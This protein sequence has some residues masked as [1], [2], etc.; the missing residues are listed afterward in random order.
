MVKKTCFLLWALFCSLAF[1]SMAS[2]AQV[3][4]Y[5]TG[6][7]SYSQWTNVGCSSGSLEWQCVDETPASTSDYLST[8]KG[9]T[10]E[11]F[12]FSS[13]NLSNVEI[14][15]ITLMYYAMQEAPSKKCFEPLLRISGTDY[16]A[17]TQC[18]SSSYAYYVQ[19]YT[20]N[21]AT[22]LAWTLSELNNLEA[23][24]ESAS[25]SGGGRVAQVFVI[26]D[27]ENID[28][29]PTAYASASP[30][31]G[32]S[33]LLVYF[34]GTGVGGDGTLSYFWD[35]GDGSNSSVQNPSHTYS[36]GNYTATLYVSDIDNDVASDSVNIYVEAANQVPT[37]Y[38]SASPTSGTTPLLVYF[39]GTGVGGDGTLSYFWDF[40]DGS[41]SSVQNPSHTYS[42]GNYTA[43]LY[44]SDIDNDVASDSVNIYVE[45]A[46]QV[47]VIA[48]YAMQNT[49]NTSTAVT[50]V[51]YFIETGDEPYNYI[52]WDFGDGTIVN[53]SMVYNHTYNA[54]GTYYANLTVVDAN[55]DYAFSNNLEILV[56]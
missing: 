7:G 54:S 40:G 17:A 21:P 26:V 56:Y 11:S 22:G 2:A 29:I 51:G 34:N 44:V 41:N 1:T 9:N 45:A 32:T 39:N 19:S 42:E 38:A 49:T 48:A 23:G 43:T 37:A 14:S 28:L 36:E 10:L 24:M 6:Q 31:S 16:T 55:W 3:T 5:P 15:N 20:T 52:L 8:K 4:L 53:G 18:T 35:F 30:T 46:N 47:P 12:T 33:P 50:F 13:T 25:S 27:Y